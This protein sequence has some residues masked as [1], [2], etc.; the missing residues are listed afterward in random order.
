MF[1]IIKTA[2]TMRTA[3]AVFDKFNVAYTK[4]T[5]LVSRKNKTKQSNHNTNRHAELKTYAT[6]K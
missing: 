6:G 3:G 2:A 4:K 1:K 5:A